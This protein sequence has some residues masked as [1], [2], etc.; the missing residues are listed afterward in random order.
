M[1][2]GSVPIFADED[3]SV[4]AAAILHARGFNVVTAR[5][6]GR[7]GHSDR[8]QI[9]FA[10]REGRVLLTHNRDDFER[11]HREHLEA[12]QA[13]AGIIVA[14]RRHATDLAARVGTLLSRWPTGEF[15]NQL[16]YV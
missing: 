9:T 1:P 5:D 8:D 3:V 12:G 10:T 16:F 7:L 4:V 15:G 14:R 2:D 11:L 13:H 6:A